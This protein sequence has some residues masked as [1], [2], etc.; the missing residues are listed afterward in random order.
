MSRIKEAAANAPRAQ[1]TFISK[2]EKAGGGGG[3]AKPAGKKRGATKPGPRKP[4]TRGGASGGAFRYWTAC[5]KK[6]QR[7]SGGKGIG[8]QSWWLLSD[9]SFH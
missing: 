8:W 2:R 7:K 1:G 6:R 5:G 9:R 4:M 3:A